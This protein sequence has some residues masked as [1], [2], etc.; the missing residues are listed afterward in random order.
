MA[1]STKRC[2]PK[3]NY[4]KFPF[5]T[6]SFICLV[7]ILFRFLQIRHRLSLPNPCKKF[8]PRSGSI[9]SR[10]RLTSTIALSV[11]DAFHFLRYTRRG[12]AVLCSIWGYTTRNFSA[13]PRR[14]PSV[15]INREPEPCNKHARVLEAFPQENI[16]I[17]QKEKWFRNTVLP[18]YV[19]LTTHV[20][21]LCTIGIVSYHLHR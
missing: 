16:K 15:N 9:P 19:L 13:D 12:T 21:Y 2:H 20:S 7:L 6:V 1:A 11:D 5:E 8:H 14:M 4:T 3:Q 18:S 10:S 17:C